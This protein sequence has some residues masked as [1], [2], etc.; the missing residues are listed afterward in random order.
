MLSPNMAGSLT[1][2][3]T[4]L[5]LNSK[6]IAHKQLKPMAVSFLFIYSFIKINTVVS[7]INDLTLS[8]QKA[9]IIY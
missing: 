4:A 7:R 1:P 6:K 9:L 2:A 3:K 5:P 8:K